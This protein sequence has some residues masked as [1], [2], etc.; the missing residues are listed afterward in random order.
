[1]VHTHLVDMYARDVSNVIALYF[2]IKP[3]FCIYY[4]LLVHTSYI[5]FCTK[6]VKHHYYLLRQTSRPRKVFVWFWHCA[7]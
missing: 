2:L 4:D 5:H 6:S 3:L 7:G 1:L